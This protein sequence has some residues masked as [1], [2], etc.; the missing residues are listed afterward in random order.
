MEHILEI[1]NVVHVNVVLLILKGPAEKV[2][3]ALAST[4]GV[5]ISTV[6]YGHKPHL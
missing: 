2:L 3:L 6:Q 5:W 4:T 1:L